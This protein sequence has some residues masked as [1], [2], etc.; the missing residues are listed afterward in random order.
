MQHDP[1]E[2]SPAYLAVVHHAEEL[3]W[4]ELDRL[5]I[6]RGSFGSCHAF[7]AAKQQVLH[8]RFGIEW[9]SPAEMNP[10]IIFD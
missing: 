8:D 9:K 7:W 5:G 10:L 1:V 3:A 2:Q 4:Q 6:P